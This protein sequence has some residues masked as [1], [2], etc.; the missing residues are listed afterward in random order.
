MGDVREPLLRALLWSALWDDVRDAR[1][2]P[3]R[4]IELALRE[5]PRE[6]DEQILPRVLGRMRRAAGAYLSPAARER[7]R[8]E[9]E[10][11]FLALADD[12]ERP[13]GIRRAA[14]DAFV[15]VA[16][17]HPRLMAL[18]TTDSAVGEPVRDPL[19]WEVATRLLVT[20]H[21]DGE[22]ALAAQTTRDA[23]PDGRRRAFIAG[24]ARRDA[25]TKRA[26][27]SRY[28]ADTTLNE[29]WASGSLGAFNAPEHAELTL[30][31]LAAAL[32]SLP[33]IQA[34]R[35]IFFLGAW[36][37]AFLNGQSSPEALAVVRSWLAREQPA[38][39][40]RKVLEYAD[41]LERTV[42]IRRSQ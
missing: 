35:R 23:T 7:L 25:V 12:T 26:Y 33:F 14:L 1:L 17:S 5:L 21:P 8:P 29:D 6:T 20:R 41:E 38:D 32:D 22:A 28:F 37:G 2:P 27:F 15:D 3:A 10:R 11:A 9:L 19:R 16:N 24:A 39:L 18:L 31:Y 40:R 30:P 42:R 36:L 4:F 34:N 13:Y